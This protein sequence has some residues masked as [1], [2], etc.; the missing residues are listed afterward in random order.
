M[1]TQDGFGVRLEWGLDG[2]EAL[3]PHCTVLIIVDVLCFTTSLDMIVGQGGRINLRPFS[4]Q[5]TTGLRRPSALRSVQ[6]GDEITMT[7]P[8]GGRLCEHAAQ[9]TKVMAGCLRN[10]AAVADKAI[11]LADRG[12]IGIVP[13][14]EQW[15]VN[16][17]EGRTEGRMRVAIEDYLG[18]G[19]LVSELLALGYNP[20]SPEAALAATTYRTAEP[21]LGDLLGGC[22]SGLELGERGLSEDIALAGQTNV[23]K[24]APHLVNGVFE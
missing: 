9:W 10:A 24:A 21:Y 22:G 17:F 16:M 20:A 3:A 11:D 7:S 13:A 4:P 18:A 5:A 6:P 2:V 8:N 14:G 15:G 1:F 12:P 23:S 19:A